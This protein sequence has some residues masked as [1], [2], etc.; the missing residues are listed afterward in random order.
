M[1]LYNLLIKTA[2]Q[3]IKIQN[4]DGSMPSGHNGP[5]FH[6]QTHIRNTCHWLI[7][8]LKIYKITNN[9]KYLTASNKCIKFLLKNKPKYNYHHRTINN[10]DKCNGLIGPTWTIEALLIAYQELNKKE[11]LELAKKLFL[12]HKF[13]KKLGLW[14]VKEIDGKDHSIDWTFNHQLWFAVIGS[15]FDKKEFPKIHNQI[16]IF[17]NKLN[18]NLKL[19]K[20]DLIWHPIAQ[21]PFNLKGL[22][23]F[24]S[25][26]RSITIYNKRDIHKSIGYHQ[27]NLYAFAILKQT[28]PNLNFW[29]SNKFKKALKF[30]E[31]KE[32]ENGLIDNKY[33][34]DY[35][36]AGIETAFILSVFKKNSEKQQIYWLEKQFNRNFDFKKNLL[37]KNTDD[38]ETLAARIYE[39]TRLKNLEL[40]L[41]NE[42]KLPFVSVI[43][44]VFNDEKRIEICIK[45]LLN[46]TYPKDKYEIII[47]DNNSTDNTP[48]IIKKYPVKLLFER[49]IQ[50]SYASRNKGLKEAK[51]EIIAFTD[52]DC[53]PK[54][55][56]LKN[57]IYSLLQNNADMVG[58]KISFIF[59][60]KKDPYEIFDSINF[61]QQDKIVLKGMSTT[62]NLFSKKNIFNKIGLFPNIISGG[63]IYWTKKATKNNFKLIYEKN[64][65]ILHPTRNKKE[66]IKKLIRIGYGDMTKLL[67]NKNKIILLLTLILGFLPPLNIKNLFEKNNNLSFIKLY[68]MKWKIKYYYNIGRIKCLKE[69]KFKKSF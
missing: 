57:G 7:L 16:K 43:V 46:Q 32:Y 17:I 52:S 62:A 55:D 40:N 37:C 41:I 3:G 4:K 2:N 8:F 65:E 6:P 42:K 64:A 60:D 30:I 31:T 23:R 49:K 51:G 50:S 19:Y 14:Y 36:V 63:D 15:M 26:I 47:V 25:A 9:E 58:G 61:L 27:F 24:L 59:K 44:P 1:K 33:G 67:K 68:I 28:Y 10:R 21:Y 53:Q 22:K 66:L 39:A 69:Y 45:K 5:Y 38:P 18:K 20:N 56:W 13:N 54:E 29:R 11:L 48:N 34:F 35:N 12:I